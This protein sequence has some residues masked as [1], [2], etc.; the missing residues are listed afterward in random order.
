MP[1]D[2]RI[3]AEKIRKMYNEQPQQDLARIL[4]TGESGSGKT[5]LATTAPKPVHIDSFDPGSSKGLKKWVDS[6]DIIVD[7]SYENEDPMNPAVF[8]DWKNT[9]ER[10]CQGKYFQAIG[11]YFLDSA[12]T[13]TEAILNFHQGKRSG[14]GTVPEWNKDYHPQKVDIRNYV[15][16]IMAQ[17][18]HFVMTG[19]LEPQKDKEGNVIAK[20]FIMTGKGAVV[21]PLLFDELWVSDSKETS[22][23]SEYFIHLEKTGI[24]LARSRLR[25]RGILQ[26]KEQANL[27]DILKR[28]GLS[29][30]DKPAL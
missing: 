3:E 16:L 15:R 28:A 8:R 6:G 12:T 13:W 14:A 18:C 17:P 11:T 29:W 27:R 26:G 1:I 22:K 9:L 7:S 20:R 2:A 4:L 19:H 24:L 25:A 10:R 21:I 23:G 30:E 5:Y